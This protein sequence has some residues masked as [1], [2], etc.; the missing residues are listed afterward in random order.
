[1]ARSRV[2]NFIALG[3]L[4]ICTQSVAQS[5][6]EQKFY[7]LYP[8]LSAHKEVVQTAYEHLKQSGF[9]AKT[10]TDAN[11]AVAIRAYVLLNQSSGAKMPHWRVLETYN[12][13]RSNEPAMARISLPEFARAMNDATGSSAFD[14]GLNDNW[15]WRVGANIDTSF[16][17]SWGFVLPMAVLGLIFLLIVFRAT[18]RIPTRGQQGQARLSGE[19]VWQR[20]MRPAGVA[21]KWGSVCGILS[22]FMSHQHLSLIEWVG[23]A[24]LFSVTIA[25]VISVPVYLIALL[26]CATRVGSQ[27]VTTP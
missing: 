1:M 9:Q 14:E 3:F 2:H 19:S 27:K 25:L 6:E 10:V 13:A 24:L 7:R 15:L 23:L 12:D 8:D 22:V 17:N 16:V 5:E 21:A 26:Y 4:T 18:A 20:A 11:R